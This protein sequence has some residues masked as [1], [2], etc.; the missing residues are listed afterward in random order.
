M[1][2]F[3]V[4]IKYALTRPEIV[5][6]YFH[7]LTASRKFLAMIVIY[8]VG[9]G[10]LPMLLNGA[11]SRGLETH[12]VIV[13]FAWMLGAFTFMPLWLFLRGKTSERTLTVS[14]DG[15]STQIG[16][17]KGEIPWSKV[18]LVADADEHVLIVGATG[19]AFFIPGRAFQGAE[20]KC[21]FVEQIKA[22]RGGRA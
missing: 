1:E 20:Q 21:E 6:S 12:D 5:R 3:N 19:N 15:I 7:S 17:M 16:S 4:T 22:W 18:K 11:F 9:L 13:A 8:S 14:Q 2:Q 10:L